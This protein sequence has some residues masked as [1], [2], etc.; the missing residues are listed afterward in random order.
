MALQSEE[1][2]CVNAQTSIS[3]PAEA[4]LGKSLKTSHVLS[5]FDTCYEIH[6]LIVKPFPKLK[7]I[8]VM[9]FIFVT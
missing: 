2:I 7:S 9:S 1:G 6:A 5:K 3:E 8:A 4:E